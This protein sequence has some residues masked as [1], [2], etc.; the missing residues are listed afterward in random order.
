MNTSPHFGRRSHI[1]K[2]TSGQQGVVLVFAL[3]ALTIMLAGAVGL[4]SS[5]KSSLASAGN[6]SF[7][8]DLVNQAELAAGVV[9][10]QFSTAGSGV[11]TPTLR[12][13]DKVALNYSAVALPTTPEGIPKALLLPDAGFSATWTQPDISA[14]GGIKLRYVVDRL[15]TG[16]GSSQQ[17][18]PEACLR[19]PNEGGSSE[20][21]AL[22]ESGMKRQAE[23]GS[24]DEGV[25]SLANPAVYRLTI[26]GTGARDTQSF[27]QVV[28][29]E[30]LT[31]PTP[32]LP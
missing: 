18:A 12:G 30:P 28:F 29:T 9:L 10:L 6:I 22:D 8:R 16:F 5:I 14:P 2:P 1:S 15:C 3:I 25:D 11:D 17:L 32:L 21:A 7:K 31:P 24:V 27:Y 13:A 20:V 19:A 26:R 4:I 23:L